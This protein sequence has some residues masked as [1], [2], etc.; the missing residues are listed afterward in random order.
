MSTQAFR[1]YFS[2]GARQRAKLQKYHVSLP[3]FRSFQKGRPSQS[4]SHAEHWIKNNENTLAKLMASGLFHTSP[5]APQR[6]YSSLR[7]TLHLQ[8]PRLRASWASSLRQRMWS[9]QLRGTQCQATLIQAV[10]MPKRGRDLPKE[11]NHLD[12]CG[13]CVLAKKG[14]LRHLPPDVRVSMVLSIN[15]EIK[16]RLSLE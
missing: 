6:T 9:P 3:W 4:H 15:G 11:A 8:H 12:N 13:A 10:P 16:T 5:L 2:T 14:L 7:L 1:D